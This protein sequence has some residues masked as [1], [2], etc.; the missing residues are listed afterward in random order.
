MLVEIQSAWVWITSTLLIGLIDY[1]FVSGKKA[2]WLLYKHT[3]THTHTLE[4]HSSQFDWL[5]WWR[6]LMTLKLQPVMW[7]FILHKTSHTLTHLSFHVVP[8]AYTLSLCECVGCGC[9]N[10]RFFWSCLHQCVCVCVSDRSAQLIS[11]V[12]RHLLL[13]LFFC[14]SFVFLHLL[15]LSFSVHLWNISPFVFYGLNI[16]WCDCLNK[17]K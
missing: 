2:K 7:P 8:F 16:R 13:P 11:W 15:C 1:W 6:L 5:T 14:F 3:H 9:S 17:E 12:D 4:I 10:E